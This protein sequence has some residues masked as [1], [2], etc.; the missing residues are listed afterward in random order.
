[1]S[2]VP[3]SFSTISCPHY[4][5]AQIARAR[6]DYGYDG[7]ELYALE[8]HR[9]TMDLLAE[10]MAAIRREL[11]RTPI[12]CINSWAVLSSPDPAER[13]QQEDRIG[14]ALRIAAELGAPVVKAFGGEFPAG[15]T[16]LEVFDYVAES[17]HRV[18]PRARD[19]GVRVVVETHDGFSLGASVRELLSRIDDPFFGA[20]WDVHHPY[21]MGE[22]VQGTAAAIGDRVLHAHVK[23]AVR[24]G[25]GWRFVL[26]GE[27]EL[28]VRPMIDALAER[29]FSG[30]ISVDWELMWHP[31]I[32]P[33][34]VA[35]PQYAESLRRWTGQTD[36]N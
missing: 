28:P 35:L 34:E 11:A 12:S 26:L 6:D 19:M 33:P 14:A 23:D 31:E 8:G 18:L 17:I 32:A 4:T 7:V 25:E 30:Y 15:R 13:R 5:L 29:D 27:G 1:M 16:E 36:A 22:P 9:L 3:I 21:R 10:R 20:L 2:A 24:D